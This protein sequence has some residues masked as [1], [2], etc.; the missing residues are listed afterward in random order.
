MR[1]QVLV[2]L[3]LLAGCVTPPRQDAV[4]TNESAP[5]ATPTGDA[6][7]PPPAAQ[8]ERMPATMERFVMQANTTLGVLRPD[9]PEMPLATVPQALSAT[10]FWESFVNP[11]TLTPWPSFPLRS[12]FETTGDIAIVLS[13]TSTAPGVSPNPRAAGFPPVGGWLGTTERHEFFLLANDA[14]DS[15]EA[16]K[17]YTVRLTAKPPRGGWFVTEGEQLALH[18]FLAYQTADG[19]PVSFVV[20]GPE[21]AGFVLPHEHFELVAPT[22]I[23]LVDETGELGPNPGPSGEMQQEPVDVPFNVPPEALYVVLEVSGAPKAGQR[24]D[25]DVSARTPGGEVIL[26]GSSPYAVEKTVLG[27]GNL[28]EFGRD[29]VA[30]VTSSASPA[31]ATYALKVTAY[32]P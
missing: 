6:S 18:P 24:V 16:N 31:G 1:A 19:S 26:G 8:G 4:E 22:A 32:T 17:V 9:E 13:F 15:I 25:I 20:G 2:V 7:A 11:L 30:H 10:A 28:R 21:P 3:L 12:A 29:L 14:P 27:P 23:V 5:T